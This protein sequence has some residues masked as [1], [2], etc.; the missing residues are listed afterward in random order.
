MNQV[1]LFRV[2]IFVSVLCLLVGGYALDLV[3]GETQYLRYIA[4]TIM[5]SLC[6]GTIHSERMREHIDWVAL[7]TLSV[8]L[9]SFCS[10]IYDTNMEVSGAVSCFALIFVGCLLFRKS[11][12]LIVW[13][14]LSAAC[15]TSVSLMVESPRMEPVSFIA[16]IAVISVGTGFLVLSQ[17]KSIRERD[18]SLAL[19]DTVFA[20]SADGLLYGRI[21]KGEVLRANRSAELLFGTQDW[22]VLVACLRRSVLA[23]I[24]DASG[25]PQLRQLAQ[26]GWA[27]D[28]EIETADGNSFW[29]NLSLVALDQRSDL[30][31]ARVTNM[32]EAKAREQQLVEAREAAEAAVQTRTQFLA[33]MSHEIRTP[34]NGVIGMTSLLQNTGLDGEQSSYVNTIRSSGESLLVII[35][36]ILDFAKIEADE[37]ELEVFPFDL[38][39]CVAD[40][41]D[42]VAPLA[43]QKDIELTLDLPPEDLGVVASDGARLRQVLVNLLSNAIKFTEVGE[44]VLQVEVEKQTGVDPTN[45]SNNACK[46]NF[47]IRD[48]GI[49]IP[50]QKLSSLF[51]PFTQADASTTRRFGGTG[52]GL[53]IC[54][55]LVELMGGTIGVTSQVNG[56]S[57]FSLH[58]L[59]PWTAAE[60]W[61]EKGSLQGKRVYAVDDNATNREVLRGLLEWFGMVVEMFSEPALLLEAYQPGVC[62]FVVTDMSMPE[63]D[64][65][66]VLNRLQQLDAQLPPVLLLTS[67]DR[68]DVDW[69]RFTHVLRKPVRPTD[70]FNALRDAA[71]PSF[72]KAESKP[73]NHQIEALEGEVVLV[74]EDNVVNQAV[75]RQILKKLGLRADIASD[76]A[77]AVKMLSAQSYK[78]VFMDVQMPHIDGLEATQLIRGLEDLRQPYIVAMTANAMAEDREMC[79]S[80][81]MDDFVAKPVSV[82]EIKAALVRALDHGLSA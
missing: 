57:T 53:S 21:S 6:L 10:F 3:R 30:L 13:C 50:G 4:S 44:V 80:A 45:A 69:N 82:S 24:P 23:H 41:V 31:L 9:Y 48:T 39:R 47:T 78:L 72:V 40:A 56:G 77:E 67:L 20:Q 42:V 37:I 19:S 66:D 8:A 52:L 63:L 11:I 46:I 32:S 74:A 59:A 73:Q 34:M 58:I 26:E 33:N 17:A 61:T 71:N 62:D 14:G 75:A 18:Q 28:M 79:L 15:L 29:G 12:P 54:K 16:C 22:N 76:G 81:G 7:L 2:T 64:G 55:N 65:V 60:S 27:A 35:N 68:G 43:A 1:Q 36:E 25:R 49:G 51:E 5:L 70:L 38:E